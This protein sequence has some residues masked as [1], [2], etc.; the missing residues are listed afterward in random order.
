MIRQG[1]NLLDRLQDL[2]EALLDGRCG[3]KELNN[4][5]TQVRDLDRHGDGTELGKVLDEIA[6]RC[7]VELAKAERG[8]EGA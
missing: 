6:L 3:L 7:A 8:S 1:E 4:I 5:R 2:H